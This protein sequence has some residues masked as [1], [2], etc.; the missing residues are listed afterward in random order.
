M[1]HQEDSCFQLGVNFM[2]VFLG[3]EGSELSMQIQARLGHRANEEMLETKQPGL[4]LF[5]S[6]SS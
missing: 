2:E 6:S 1:R 3:E 5:P 4:R